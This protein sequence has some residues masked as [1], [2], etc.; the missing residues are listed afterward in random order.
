LWKFISFPDNQDV[1]DLVDKKRTGI[2]ELLDEQCIVP[3]PESNDHNTCM[4]DVVNTYD[5]VHRVLTVS[6]TSSVL[7]MTLV[8]WSI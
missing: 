1:L 7:I 2:L 8:P 6:I 3:V 5:S 4:S